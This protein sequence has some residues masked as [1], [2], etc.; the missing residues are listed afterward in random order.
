MRSTL[1]NEMYLFK[2]LWP[3]K[4]FDFP[5]RVVNAVHQKLNQLS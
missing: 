5:I 2:F 4:Q 3:E 1:P